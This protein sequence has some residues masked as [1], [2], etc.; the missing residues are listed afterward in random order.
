[1]A[2]AFGLV[3]LLVCGWFFFSRAANM[4]TSDA[5]VEIAVATPSDAEYAAADAKLEQFRDALRRDQA[6][7]VSFSA[8]DLNALIARH[9]DFA[10][11]RGRIQVAIDGDVA[12]LE[13]SVSLASLPLP[14]MKHRWFNGST[15]FTFS[16]EGREFDFEPE[17]IEAN[18]HQ[19]TGNFLSSFSSSFNRSF[20]SSFHESLEKNGTSKFWNNVQSMTLRDGQLIIVTRGDTGASV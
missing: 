16:Y 1:M 17:W 18:G 6:T 10:S 15:R 4:F 19:L 11:Q 14:R 8:A 20:T 12:T 7:T 5:P 2:A 13:M 3:L 9:P